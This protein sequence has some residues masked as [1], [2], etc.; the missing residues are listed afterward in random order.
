[1]ENKAATRMCLALDRTIVLALESEREQRR[2]R[3]PMPR[4]N[5]WTL[6]QA[7]VGDL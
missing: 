4:P 7:P 2:P 1:M 3:P 6:R 5:R